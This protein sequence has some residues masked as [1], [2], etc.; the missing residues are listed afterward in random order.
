[1]DR[2][3]LGKFNLDRNPSSGDLLLLVEG[4][5][6]YKSI[7]SRAFTQWYFSRTFEDR[8]GEYNW[9]IYIKGCDNADAERLTKFCKLLQNVVFIDDDLDESFALAFHTKTSATGYKRTQ[10]GQLVR[11]AKPYDM[12]WNAGSQSKAQELAALMVEF[13]QSHPTYTQAD[14]ILA[15]PPSNPNKPFDL[16]TFLV[17]TIVQSTSQTPATTSI[18]KVRITRPMKECR[19]IQ[20]KIDNI[21]DAFALDASIFQGKNV[22]IVDDIYQTGFS[23]NE[24]GRILQQAGAKLVLG[25]VA[26][27]TT[28]DLSED[29]RD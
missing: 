7:L 22:I 5:T 16:P 12:G 28:Q 21:K 4:P 25:L 8:S 24:L 3:Q 20:E 23:I 2:Y 11:D 6:M 15:V 27:K 10:M 17:E 29:L 19:T 9:G 13:I 18:R 1:M 14:L 26:T